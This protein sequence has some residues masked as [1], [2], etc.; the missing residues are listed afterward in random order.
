LNFV[1]CVANLPLLVLLYIANFILLT[2]TFELTMINTKPWDLSQQMIFACKDGN[3][4]LTIDSQNKQFHSE[5]LQIEGESLL[6]LRAKVIR[7]PIGNIKKLSGRNILLQSFVVNSNPENHH[8]KMSYSLYN[9]A[10]ELIDMLCL[11]KNLDDN[12]SVIKLS[13]KCKF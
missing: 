5:V 10:N 13:L 1:Y 6:F 8:L 3:V 2:L 9:E 7:Y 11:E 12:Q 4:Y